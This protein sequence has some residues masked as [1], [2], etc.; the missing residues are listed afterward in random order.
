MDAAA[1]RRQRGPN[2][3]SLQCR[4]LATRAHTFDPQGRCSPQAQASSAGTRDTGANSERRPQTT[5]ALLADGVIQM[6]IVPLFSRSR[7]GTCLAVLAGVLAACGAGQGNEGAPDIT[8]PPGMMRVAV[9]PP[10]AGT[11]LPFLFPSLA[12]TR[13]IRVMSAWVSTDWAA[14]SPAEELVIFSDASGSRPYWYGESDSPFNSVGDG[15]TLTKGVDGVASQENTLWR[16][17][18]RY[19][20]RSSWVYGFLSRSDAIRYA[21]A[22]AG[23][24]LDRGPRDGTV[25]TSEVDLV[26]A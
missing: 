16:I 15:V 13:L 23:A 24:E 22:F 19:G 3:Y 11:T 5:S 25:V 21:A 12:S 1:T 4:L 2:L 6:A 7:L 14:D 20:A 9:G 18:W 10:R 17:D 26:P 8:N